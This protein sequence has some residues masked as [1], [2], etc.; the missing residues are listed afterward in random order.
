MR[1]RSSGLFSL[2]VV[3]A[4][5]MPSSVRLR[6]QRF[7]VLGEL[8]ELRAAD[9]EVDLAVAAADVERLQVADADAQVA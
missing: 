9:R 1:A 6:A 3:S 5:T 4:S 7:G 8:L 2:S